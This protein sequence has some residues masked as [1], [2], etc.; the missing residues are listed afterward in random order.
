MT[1]EMKDKRVSVDDRLR[2]CQTP[3]EARRKLS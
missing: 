1:G 2:M 3:E